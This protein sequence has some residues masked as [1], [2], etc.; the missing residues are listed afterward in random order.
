M[1]LIFVTLYIN[2]LFK[3]WQND[4]FRL[5]DLYST[6]LWLQKQCYRINHIYTSYCTCNLKPWS[7]RVTIIYYLSIMAPVKVGIFL[8]SKLTVLGVDVLETASVRSWDTLANCDRS[9][10]K[11]PTVGTYASEV[12][13]GA[14]EECWL[15]WCITFPFISCGRHAW[16][17]EEVAP[18]C[19]LRRSQKR[20]EHVL[21]SV[22]LGHIWSW[23]SVV[24]GASQMPSFRVH[25]FHM[26]PSWLF[27]PNRAI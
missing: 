22:L 9:E 16:P 19:S 5:A 3:G 25:S 6:S 23:L 17:R 10:A 15:V 26:N 27:T 8:G 13:H 1:Q 24:C 7:G 4:L 14:L 2:T 20:Q 18:I 11:V 21:G 12:D